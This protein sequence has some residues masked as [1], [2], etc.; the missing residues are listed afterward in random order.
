MVRDERKGRRNIEGSAEHP[1]ASRFRSTLA[2]TCCRKPERR[3]IVDGRQ[4]DAVPCS[5]WNAALLPLSC[6]P[7]YLFDVDAIAH[8]PQFKLLQAYFPAVFERSHPLAVPGAV[9]H[10]HDSYQVVSIENSTLNCVASS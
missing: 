3:R 6:V 9:G 1:P 4:S 7:V 10:I 8:Q 2:L 5:A